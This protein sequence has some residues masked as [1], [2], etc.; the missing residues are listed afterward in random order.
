MPVEFA[1]FTDE[2]RHTV[3]AIVDRARRAYLSAGM[4]PPTKMDLHMDISAV[5]AR[6][7]LRLDDWL[8]ADDF[9]FTHDVGGIRR[10]LNRQTGELMD[11]FVPRFARGEG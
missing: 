6:T 7:P 10:H 8:E 2:E 5:A 1:K 9:N 3:D 11:C 4:E